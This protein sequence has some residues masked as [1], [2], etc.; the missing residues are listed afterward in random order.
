LALAALF[1][2]DGGAEEFRQQLADWATTRW[3]TTHQPLDECIA[4]ECDARPTF[5]AF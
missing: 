3:I 2:A 4:A 1:F 5:P